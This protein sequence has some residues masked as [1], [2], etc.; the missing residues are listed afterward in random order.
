MSSLFG[1]VWLYSL[2][3]VLVGAGATWL[4]FVR[5]ARRRIAELEDELARVDVPK[6][7]AEAKPSRPPVFNAAPAV[8]A[9]PERPERTEPPEPVQPQLVDPVFSDPVP[10]QVVE[11]APPVPTEEVRAE[12]SDADHEPTPTSAPAPVE[13]T[14]LIETAQ[15]EMPT[16]VSPR[17]PTPTLSDIP[18]APTE[19][20]EQLQR[21]RDAEQ[22]AAASRADE[23][24]LFFEATTPPMG[25]SQAAI[26]QELRAAG[27]ADERSDRPRPSAAPRSAQPTAPPEV[28]PMEMELADHTPTALIPRVEWR[29]GYPDTAKPA[30]KTPDD[31]DDVDVDEPDA[32]ASSRPAADCEPERADTDDFDAFSR[33]E[34]PRAPRPQQDLAEPEIPSRQVAF[35]RGSAAGRNADPDP[36]PAS[37]PTSAQPTA[38]SS[39]NAQPA[40]ADQPTA[41]WSES[42]QPT[43]VQ[44]SADRPIAA[45][46]ESA[47]AT[48]AQR[49]TD[50][51]TTAAPTSRQSAAPDRQ[52]PAADQAAS[53]RPTSAEATAAEPTTAWPASAQPQPTTVQST[54]AQP[55]HPEALPTAVQPQATQRTPDPKSEALR[56]EAARREAELRKL[57]EQ[58]QPDRTRS[59][60]EPV[61]D[62]DAPSGSSNGNRPGH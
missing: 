31:V 17:R 60:F 25:I 10:T 8:L 44:P 39:E 38:S 4:I 32:G 12:A 24:P 47:Q 27:A 35:S 36:D 22:A 9:A 49:S 34:R 42:A 18:P 19:Y 13:E 26:Q 16:A 52:A 6:A 50:Q 7:A 61:V 54:P 62:P 55:S 21:Q 41:A 1:E 51:P 28:D 15:I 3:A 29:G 57:Q 11:P 46:S 59:L 45:W 30:G 53:T 40:S 58:H 56:A 23:E 5:P 48:T 43:S 33:R 20:L 2:L 37:Q 14:A